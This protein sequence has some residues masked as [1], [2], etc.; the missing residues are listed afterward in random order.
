MSEAQNLDSCMTINQIL[1]DSFDYFSK[2]LGD[3]WVILQICKKVGYKGTKKAILQIV[4]SNIQL[5]AKV[6]A[7]F[8]V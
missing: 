1:L 4:Q 8:Q 6:V 3:L 5:Y 2:L 7:H